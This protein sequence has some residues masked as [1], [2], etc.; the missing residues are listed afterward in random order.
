MKNEAILLFDVGATWTR[1]AF[2]INK[3]IVS[4]KII[5][6]IEFTLAD[7]KKII[8]ES[9]RLITVVRIACAGPVENGKVI[10]THAN[11]VFDERSLSTSLGVKV[12]LINDLEAAAF[13]LREK[14]KG[15][16]LIGPGTG[17][18]VSI[19]SGKGDVVASEEGHNKIRRESFLNISEFNHVNIP[20]YETV[21]SGKYN[22]LLTL[23]K[24]EKV[25]LTKDKF[26]EIYLFFLEEFIQEMLS[27]HKDKGLKKIIFFGGVI[28]GNKKFFSLYSKILKKK[29]KK[30]IKI[31]DD[32]FLCLEGAALINN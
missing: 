1:Y 12:K 27:K 7:I 16:L 31:I 24:K 17:L 9:G 4:K 21:L 3:K 19:I 32:K 28:S 23:F 14:N 6:T 13:S 2:L 5:L 26:T 25:I 11:L 8:L 29:F 20:D 22:V 30:E 18:G 15:S 10:M